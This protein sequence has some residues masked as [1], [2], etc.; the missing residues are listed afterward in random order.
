MLGPLVLNG[1]GGQINGT[2]IITVHNRGSPERTTK[3]VEK[4]AQPARLRDSIGYVV[5]LGLCSTRSGDKQK[6]TITI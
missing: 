1:V 5:V 3:P 2:D 4:L 6:I